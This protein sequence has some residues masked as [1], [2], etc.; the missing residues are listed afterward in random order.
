[1]RVTIEDYYSS[2]KS[3]QKSEE[4]FFQSLSLYDTPIL[5]EKFCDLL[6][7]N[8]SVF[9]LKTLEKLYG[10]VKVDVINQRSF[11]EIENVGCDLANPK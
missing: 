11:K 3:K 4:D 10:K 1:M 9:D 7:M 6:K 5:F 2:I 8:D